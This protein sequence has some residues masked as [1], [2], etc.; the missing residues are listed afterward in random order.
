TSFNIESYFPHM[1]LNIALKLRKLHPLSFAHIGAFERFARSMSMRPSLPPE[2]FFQ[3]FLNERDMLA[4][5]LLIW[6]ASL[7]QAIS[8]SDFVLD[9]D[10]F[11]T[12]TQHRKTASDW[13]QTIGCPIDFSDCASPSYSELPVPLAEFDRMLD[14]AAR[15]IRSNASTLVVSNPNV[16]RKRLASLSPL[17]TRLL[18]SALAD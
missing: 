16:M 18:R 10:F 4:V 7:L 3:F 1:M 12:D 11:S 5:F 6:I 13:F 9:V 17:S 2:Q 14:D 15:A 8:F